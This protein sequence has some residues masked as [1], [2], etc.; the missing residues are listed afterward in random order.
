MSPD[1]IDDRRFRPHLR[2]APLK[3]M[4]RKDEIKQTVSFPSSPEDGSI[5][6]GE[7]I[8]PAKLQELIRNRV[9]GFAAIPGIQSAEPRKLEESVVLER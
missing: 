7:S 8:I 1:K 6:A 5:E 4:R 3:R 9:S 2:T